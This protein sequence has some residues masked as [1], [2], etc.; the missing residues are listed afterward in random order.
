MKRSKT[1]S[2]RR[3]LAT[4]FVTVIVLTAG[5]SGVTGIFGN[6]DGDSGVEPYT[7]SGDEL[8]GEMLN[9]SHRDT[10]R[11]AGSYTAEVNI[12]LTSD[13]SSI[14]QDTRGKVDLEN[15]RQYVVQSA[16][17]FGNRTTYRYM[18]DNVTYEK[19]VP[20]GG[21]TRYETTQNAETA[22][23]SV[24]TDNIDAFEWEQRGTETHEGVGVTRYEATGVANYSALPTDA[25]EDNISDLS[26]T[27]LVTEDGVMYEYTVDYTRESDS[28]Q[29]LSLR[30]ATRDIG[31]TTVEEPDWLDEAQSNSSH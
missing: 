4:L 10:L 14:T 2:V 22:S 6:D 15:D 29:E 23:A 8:T 27:L 19:V 31:S 28:T 13:E 26:A 11:S 9:E 20:E 12:S 17:L 30:Y 25:S 24:N 21:E 16:S 3:I 7:E 5:C 18:A 1:Q